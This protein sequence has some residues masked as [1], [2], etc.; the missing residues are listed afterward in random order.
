MNRQ[1]KYIIDYLEQEKEASL[2]YAII[3]IW[4]VSLFLPSEC[5]SEMLNVVV[6]KL[7]LCTIGCHLLICVAA[8]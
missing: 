4:S 7:L 6:L 8:L 2:L 1:G 5:T 3:T